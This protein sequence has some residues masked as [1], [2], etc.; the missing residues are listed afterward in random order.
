MRGLVRPP[1]AVYGRITRPAE[2]SSHGVSRPF[3]YAPRP[4]ALIAPGRRRASA[5][6]PPGTAGRS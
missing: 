4:R 6:G 1:L 5:A 3:A 2:S